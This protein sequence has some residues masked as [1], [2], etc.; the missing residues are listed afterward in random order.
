MH[1]YF[2]NSVIRL[3]SIP[4]LRIVNIINTNKNTLNSVQGYSTTRVRLPSTH[5]LTIESRIGADQVKVRL[6]QVAPSWQSVTTA[7]SHCSMCTQRLTSQQP[8]NIHF[9]PAPKEEPEN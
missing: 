5:K 9:A 2:Y 8:R 7:G 6:S 1:L 3:V 4:A